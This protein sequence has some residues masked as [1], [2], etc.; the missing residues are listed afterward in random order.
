M[1]DEIKNFCSKSR[2]S[3]SRTIEWLLAH[4]QEVK[5]QI[6]IPIEYVSSFGSQQLRIRVKFELGHVTSMPNMPTC[7]LLK[8]DSR[9]SMFRAL[10][11]NIGGSA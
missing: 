3:A 1:F 4:P 9:S 8:S 6:R 7:Q 11:L 10:A 5:F 2:Y